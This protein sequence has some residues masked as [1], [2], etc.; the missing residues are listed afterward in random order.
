ELTRAVYPFV[1]RCRPT[2][3][4]LNLELDLWRVL[5]ETVKRW[6]R[7]RPAAT[8]PDEVEAW[9]GGLLLDL[10][11]SAFSVALRHGIKGVLL[12]LELRLYQVFRAEIR[13]NRGR[14]P[15]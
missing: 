13:R 9:R 3:S 14:T 5:A 10:T 1:L 12:K 8:P 2:A 15:V 6:A 7:Q 4:W 11:G